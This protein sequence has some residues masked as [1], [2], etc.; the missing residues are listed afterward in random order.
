MSNSGIRQ[1]KFFLKDF[2]STRA[3][4]MKSA[5]VLPWAGVWTKLAP[6]PVLWSSFLSSLAECVV[7]VWAFRFWSEANDASQ[8][9]RMKISLILLCI[10]ALFS[11][12]GLQQ[13]SVSPGP[14]LERVVEGLT[15]RPEVQKVLTN[16]YTLEQAFEDSGFRATAVWTR[17][18]VTFM[19]VAL[20]VFWVGMFTSLSVYLASFVI[21]LRRS[22]RGARKNSALGAR[23]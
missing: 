9:R 8:D 21:G 18:S 15:I 6:P 5:I 23:S 12:A 22:P 4:A 2:R 17:S 20:N 3:L 19:Q 13:F 14:R 1:F 7:L 10:S 11:F 16:G